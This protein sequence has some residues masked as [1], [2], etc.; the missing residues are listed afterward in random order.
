[1]LNRRIARPTLYLNPTDVMLYAEGEPVTVTVAGESY[2]VAIALSESAPAG[3]GL[4]CGVPGARPM[5]L[6]PAI[7][8]RSVEPV[9]AD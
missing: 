8:G 1:L 7:V 4:L 5:G 9:A 2:E 6:E 3:V